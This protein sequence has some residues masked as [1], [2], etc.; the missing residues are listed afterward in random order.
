[1]NQFKKNLNFMITKIDEKYILS[2]GQ[3]VFEI[4][5]IGARIYDLCNGKNTIDD[6]SRKLS[7]FYNED[8]IILEQEVKKFMKSLIDKKIIKGK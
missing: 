4:N 7:D 1:M 5:E 3:Q 6:I 2:D 8:F